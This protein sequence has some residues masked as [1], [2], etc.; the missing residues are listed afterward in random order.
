MDFT[1]LAIP[2]TRRFPLVLESHE[3]TSISL[4]CLMKNTERRIEDQRLRANMDV[5]TTIPITI[6]KSQSTIPI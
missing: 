3:V 6:I 5:L 4:C 1:G 2:K